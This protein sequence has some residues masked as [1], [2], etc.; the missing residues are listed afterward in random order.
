MRIIQISDS[1]IAHD[2]PQR[3]R[4]LDDCVAA[5]NA[6]SP[7][8]I[9]HTGDITHNGLAIEYTAAR[10]SLDKLNTSYC[11]LPGNKDIRSVLADTFHDHTY[12]AET[13]LTQTDHDKSTT[14]AGFIQYTLEQYPVRLIMIDTVREST[15]K[16]ELCEQ[17]LAH[18][19][20]MLEQDTSKPVIVFMHHSPFI[21]EEIPDPYQF[22]NWQDVEA[23]EKVLSR[24]GNIECIYCGHVHRNV[25]GT[26]GGLPVHVLSCIATDLRKGELTTE[27]KTRPFYRIID[28]PC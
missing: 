19:E 11:V 14:A 1:H 7:D 6:E 15:S 9:I 28:L 4:D 23:F 17:R 22:H 20:E 5:V 2:I 10:R 24:Y 8:L 25:E 12:L 18:L 16:G 26:I 27:D 13:G 21:V 3:L